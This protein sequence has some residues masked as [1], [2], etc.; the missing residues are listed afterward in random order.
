VW[1]YRSIEPLAPAGLQIYRSGD[2]LAR[3][4]SDIETLENFYVRA[5][6]PPLSAALVTGLACVLLGS[7]DLR[8]G[9]VLL[10]FL[11]L[12]GIALPLANRRFSR[13]PAQEMVRA[14]AELNTGLVDQIQGL[15][16]LLI[17][18]QETKQ[19]D[20]LARENKNLVQI[21]ERMAWIRGSG[22]ALVAFFTGLAGLA[23]LFLAIPLVGSGEIDGVYLA[24]LPL[25]AIASFEAVQPLANAMGQ[26]QASIESARRLFELID[27]TPPV[28]EPH[29]PAPLPV[30]S[31]LVVQD[32]SFR[33]A[34]DEPYILQKVSFNLPVGG[35][36]A[37]V[38]PSGAGKSSLVNLLLRFWDYSEGS[39]QLGNQDLCS[40]PAEEVRAFFAVV[41]QRTHLFNVTIWDNLLLANPDASEEQILSA[42]RI[43]QIHDFILTL[44]QGYDTLIGEN[45][46]L[47]S[48]GQRKRLA[49]A[50]A[51]LKDAAILLLDEPTANL[52]PITERILLRS[53]LENPRAQTILVITHRL[54]GMENM[55][56]ILVMEAGQIVQ[57]GGHKMLIEQDGL[58]RQM[59]LAQNQ[60]LFEA[61]ELNQ[62]YDQV[63]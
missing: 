1:F 49:I 11:V 9:L 52:D 20:W 43:A 12:T 57:R 51:L 4:V 44:P 15:A 32:L 10:V 47:L 2:L 40:L 30:E 50:R 34:P 7:F 14:R 28:S 13:Q 35:R 17:N 25:A 53:I 54:V 36:L 60:M 42:C 16:D 46:Y 56:E 22:D 63:K 21:Q 29:H 5:V 19:L 23:I 6:I 55:D 33:Y 26:T 27:S 18:N 61:G 3:I 38:G 37:I 8:L 24:L 59:W 45:G 39:L 58:Y 62:D 48:G 41:P 31:N